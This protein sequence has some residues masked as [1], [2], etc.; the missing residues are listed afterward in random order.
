MAISKT[1]KEK[2]YA[3][4]NLGLDVLRRREDG[5]HEVKMIMQ[6]I[7]ICDEITFATSPST[8]GVNLIAD[9]DNLPL[10]GTNLIIK[11][12]NLMMEKYNIRQG[13]DIRLIKNIPMASGMAGG[14][15][16]AAATLRGLNKLFGLGLT[17][18]E[19][20]RL[21]VK[22]G[23]D[24]PFCVYGGTYLS[25]GIGEKLTRLPD[26]PHCTVLI[27]KP[28]FG[29]STGYVYAN[30]HVENIKKHPD[31]DSVIDSINRKDIKSIASNIENILENV[32]LKDYPFVQELKDI[33]NAHGAMKSLM[34]GS[35][36]TV[37]GLFD[38]KANAERAAVELRALDEVGDVVVTCFEDLSSDEVRKKAQIRIT[39]SMDGED[40]VEEVHDCVATEK[41][42][43]ISIT[44]YEKDKDSKYDIINTL[45]ISDRK[46]LYTKS[47]AVSTSMLITPDESTSSV[48]STAYGDINIDIICHEF[49]LNEIADRLV[50]EID[51]DIMQGYESLNHCEMKIEVE[52]NI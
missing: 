26:V 41:R 37:F 39:S 50:L 2:A 35:G 46:L 49:V 24:V 29:V 38:N 20:C 11:A 32:T 19:L 13:V 48:Y 47:G 14:S 3:K 36:P 30:L 51:Y 43:S 5:Y 6:T 16:D 9:V 42:G 52:Y 40:P 28:K 23:A 17:E 25:E 34:S 1:V 44:Y 7:G 18:E 15:S 8:E 33:M 31:I 21:G 10:D 45:T 4:I 22:I 27:A 12:A